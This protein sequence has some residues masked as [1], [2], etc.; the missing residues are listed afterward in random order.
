MSGTTAGGIV[1]AGI[2]TGPA[3]TDAAPM[4]DTTLMAVLTTMAQGVCGCVCMCVCVS[5]WY[6][7]WP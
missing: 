1:D 6:T 5:V 7:I 2:T 4:A 3:A